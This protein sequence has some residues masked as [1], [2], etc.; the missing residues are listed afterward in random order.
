MGFL[1]ERVGGTRESRG[2]LGRRHRNHRH[3]RA[4][5]AGSAASPDDRVDARAFLTARLF[6]LL[7]GDWDRHAD[8]WVLGPLWGHDAPPLGSHPARPGP[9]PGEIRR[10]PALHRPAE[11]SPADQLWPEV[12]LHPGRH[13]ERSRSRPAVP[14]RAGVA[15]LGIG[16]GRAAS[17]AHRQRH[18]RGGEG[19]ATTA[20]C[21]RGRQSWPPRFAPGG[22]TFPR[23]P[24]ATI[25]CWE[26]R[27]MSTPPMAPTRREATRGP[28]GMVE[29][30]LSRTRGALLPPA[31]RPPGHQGGAGVSGW[32]RRPARWWTG[33]ESGGPLLRIIGGEGQ[34]RLVD[35]TGSGGERFY[36]DPRGPARVQGS[37]AGV[38]RR[39]YV[40]AR[41]NPKALAARAIGE[42]AGPRAPR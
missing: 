26:S 22:T 11:R 3:R 18:R 38:D 30:T 7:I 24:N 4:A 32:W 10:A 28:D 23:R 15:D 39:P 13:L 1:E 33:S 31:V 20:L 12:S 8:Q 37:G 19:A 6:D 16:G 35:S 17:G 5:L 42:A 25:A 14:E 21:S 36:D 40:V 9:G 29:L 41:K 27:S 34:D 2:A